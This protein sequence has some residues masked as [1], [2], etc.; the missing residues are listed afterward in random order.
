MES[1]TEFLKFIF[2]SQ[3]VVAY[4]KGRK[5]EQTE[6]F[7]KMILIYYLCF[8]SLL[9]LPT[10][11]STLLIDTNMLNVLKNFK[12]VRNEECL[13]ILL[14]DWTVDE[15]ILVQKAFSTTG[16]L[17]LDQNVPNMR[18]GSDQSCQITIFKTNQ[19]LKTADQVC[20]LHLKSNCISIMFSAHHGKEETHPEDKTLSIPVILVRLRYTPQFMFRV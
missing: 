9:F 14:G 5:P 3:T 20:K 15:T 11:E 12:I 13:V 17:R 1:A 8:T 6:L 18:F 10:I 4:L 2:T 19:F 16:L 7:W